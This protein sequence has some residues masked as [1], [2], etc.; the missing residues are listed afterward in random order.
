VTIRLFLRPFRTAYAWI[1][2]TGLVASFTVFLL[3]LLWVRDEQSYDRFHPNYQQL[4]RL[5]QYQRTDSLT[6]YPIAVTPAPLAAYLASTFPEIQ[7]TTRVAFDEFFM[8][9]EDRGYYNKGVTTDSTFFSMFGFEIAQG[10]PFGKSWEEI[11]LSPAMA[12]RYFGDDDPLGKTLKIGPFF[13]EVVGLLKEPAGQSHFAPDF[14]LPFE[15]RRQAGFDDFTN[16]NWSNYH[17]YA[18][19]APQTDTALLFAKTRDALIK[20]RST[21]AKDEVR[22]QP[23]ADIHLKS[24]HLNN[25]ILTHG[26]ITQVQAFSV[27]GLLVLVIAC[28]NYANLS[29]AQALR[30]S[31]EVGVR[32][33]VGASR[34]ELALRAFAE[35][36][37]QCMLALVVALVLAWLLLPSFN[38]FSGKTL[39]M[40]GAPSQLVLV[41]IVLVGIVTLV[42]GAYPAWLLSSYHPVAALKGQFVSGRTALWL[43]RS[44][45]LV[46]FIIAIALMA[47]TW[48]VQQQLHHLAT[49]DPGVQKDNILVSFMHNAVRRQWADYKAELQKLPGVL[50]VTATQEK[51]SFSDATT[52]YM[53]W[54]GK[55]EDQEISFHYFMTDYDFVPTFGVRLLEGRGFDATIASD[56]NAV[57]LNEAAVRQMG[58]TD[59]VNKPF[60]IRKTRP[61]RIIG[62]VKDFNFK[63]AHRQVEPLVIYLDP[64]S[65][66]YVA[67]RFAGSPSEMVARAQAVFKKF[68]A[69]RP[70]DYSFLTDDMAQLHNTEQK[71]GRLLL[72][73]GG[74][75]ILVSCLGLLGMV[76]FAAG[77]RLREVAIRKA[78]GA[79]VPQLAW[80]LSAEF[81]ALILV[82]FGL[83]AGPV[84]Y[85]AQQWLGTFAYQADH[86]VSA[87]LL[88]GGLSLAVGWLTVLFK[89]VP[90]ALTDPVKVLRSE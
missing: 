75:S 53:D 66:N 18:L 13:I 30:R 36:G 20:N 26:S 56:S 76:L 12:R 35:V 44:L 33:V 68:S 69:E 88:A 72:I 23:L 52:T 55:T 63:S 74:L 5:V 81:V 2:L 27:M 87:L 11:V 67:I 24:G 4:Y 79:S 1:N 9:F 71:L 37:V 61:G 64:A 50:H 31:K 39:T 47:G 80:M 6:V 29:T 22:W 46:Q 62:I 28:I 82:A 17:T 89:A 70:Y 41:L 43:R 77:Q 73:L 58:I 51:I 48:V 19:V 84:Y 15:L 42:G 7:Q 21:H 59:P 3:T 38:S 40:D 34:S 45:V 65:L 83:T 14:I 25:D 49:R 90:V 86:T 78:M 60:T 8:L 85:V 16:W 57:L 54:E 10:R 32:K